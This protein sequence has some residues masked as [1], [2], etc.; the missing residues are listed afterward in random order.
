[1]ILPPSV[2]DHL[3]LTELGGRV[4][5]M[6]ANEHSDFFVRNCLAVVVEVD[7]HPVAP[8]RAC[9]AALPGRILEDPAMHRAAA[10][11]VNEAIDSNLRPWRRPD[12]AP[13]PAFDVFPLAARLWRS[14]RRRPR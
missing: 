12:P 10:A 11:V 7:L 5:I 2:V 6:V 4:S 14:L 3:D 1:M 8:P 9:W 13:F